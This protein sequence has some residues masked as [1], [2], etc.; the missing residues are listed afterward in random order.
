VLGATIEDRL[1]AAIGAPVG[2]AT[3]DESIRFAI[4]FS[5]LL[6]RILTAQDLD[7]RAREALAG[8]IRARTELQPAEIGVLLDL[9]LTPE[10]RIAI[11]DDELRAYEAR[12]GSAS[13]EALRQSLGEEL[14]LRGFAARYGEAEALLLLD[15]LFQI[16]ATDGRISRAEIGR[17]TGA[18]EQLGI[19]RMLVGALFRKYDARHQTGELTVPLD[20]DRTV[21]GHA[22]HL[23]VPLPDP[24]VAA[25][26]AEV[27][28]TS[29]G[30]R[31][32]DLRSGR[33]TLLNGTPIQSAPFRPGDE[34]K[35]GSY[36]LRLDPDATR[37]EI[38]STQSF[39]ALSVRG[40]RRR[41]G[42]ATLLDDVNFTVFTGEVVAI[43]GP[44]GS[45]KTTLLNAITGIA[46][47]DE[48]DVIFDG[49]SFHRLLA[50]D[51]SIVGIVPQDDVVHPEL[52]VEESLWYTARLRFPPDARADA[53]Q[54]E[55]DRVLEEL[56]IARIRRSRIGDAV[57]RGIS[58]GQRK[59]V[60]LGQELLTRSTRVLFLDEPTSGLDPQTAQGIV[61]L[62]RQ[63]ADGGRIVFLVTHDV[64]GAILSMV[65]HL[66]VLAPGG[67][68]AWFGPPTEATRWFGVKTV[69]EIFAK[70]PEKP[71]ET[72]GRTYREGPAFR[73]FVR[74][75][76][77][78]LGLDGVK[79]EGGRVVRVRRSVR[80]QFRTLTARYFRTK[81]RDVVGMLVLLAQAPIL[82]L[83]MWAVFPAPDPPAMFMLALSSLWFGAS[84]SVREM[85]ADRSIWRREARVG[86][87]ALPYVASKVAVM[88]MV[89]GLQCVLLSTMC[90]VLLP[91]WG[92]YGYN[93][94]L[95]SFTASLTGW[96][97]MALGLFLSASLA[98]SEAA[99]GTLPLVLI[100]QITFSGLLVKVKEMGFLAKGLSYLM[101]V[102]Y[103][104][105]AII[106][107]GDKLT[108]PL[109]GGQTE[110]AAKPLSG[111]LY[112]LG[113]KST[114]AAGDM[115]IPYPA[116][117]LV[118]GAIFAALLLAT[119]VQTWRTREGN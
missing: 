108:E 10:N 87:R 35:L 14:D 37:L 18:A 61:S 58:G 115:G 36:T 48:G 33:P 97:G 22:T 76:E 102:R 111:I 62:V 105:E 60:N 83:F 107:T 27:V 89:V 6:A 90:W 67:R 13:A 32:V 50:V 3:R 12:F 56:D 54:G 44:S 30:F 59:R 114:A 93:W 118:L 17:L 70:L 38:S 77:H 28:R 117:I 92:E 84:G 5:R 16:C 1:R 95:L 42:D 66:M 63:L 24:Q 11:G 29:D 41:I 71:P 110:R 8:A 81:R 2:D 21:I 7:R 23:D 86:V 79:P 65:D 72:W 15:G 49:R 104:F 31:V 39:S 46:P 9:V 106:K 4:E 80:R 53:L 101:I 119:L 57:K 69:D 20:Q 113:F 45:G 112:N 82:G 73:K 51:Q 74:T 55:V 98:S 47:A 91:M 109:V 52:T 43:V 116:L 68:L 25:R 88:G 75:R 40:L 96:I 85:I 94:F 78:L 99:V 103:S 19:D 64:S 100:P 34:L 26:H